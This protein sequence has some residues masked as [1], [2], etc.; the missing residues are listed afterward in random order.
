MSAQ[1]RSALLMGWALAACGATACFFLP[2][3]EFPCSSNTDCQVLPGTT[4][5]TQRGLCESHAPGPQD[6]GAADDDRIA[7][8]GLSGLAAVPDRGH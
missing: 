5:N 2:T 4:C 3:D 8:A 1:R 6:G 7:R